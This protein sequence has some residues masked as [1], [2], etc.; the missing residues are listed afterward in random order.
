MTDK[1]LADLLRNQ[2]SLT[3]WLQEINHEEAEA[4][5]QEDF[6]KRERLKV[7]NEIIGLPFDRPVQFTGREVADR[8]PA[9]QKFLK[10]EGDESYALR[11]MPLKEGLPKQRLRGETVNNSLKWFEGLGVNPYDYRIDF[12]PHPPDYQ[13]ATIFVVTPKGIYGEIVMGGHNQLTQGFHDDQPPITFAYDYKDWHLEPANKDALAHLKELTGMIKVTDPALQARIKAEL[14]GD[15]F[16]DYLAGYFESSQ[17][18]LGTWYIDYNRILGK[19]Y[20][21][22]LAIPDSATASQALLRGPV[23]CKGKVTG[24]ARVLAIDGHN[25]ADFADGEILVCPVTTPDFIPL[26]RKAAA[27]I[28]DQGGIL[29]H[30]AIVARELNKPCIVGTREATTK[31]KTG[32]TITVD[33]DAGIVLA[34]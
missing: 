20:A 4:L 19:F 34:A 15:F 23:G 29:S 17:S 1:K 8:A 33:A 3:E 12:V 31:L 26:M 2:I 32:Q 21:D 6:D 5:R 22:G 11:A 13:W 28:T 30:A 24:V 27:I 9:F 10:E 25:S 18:S 14:G 16:N 7:L